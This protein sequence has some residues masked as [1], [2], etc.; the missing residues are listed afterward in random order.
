MPNLL[1]SVFSKDEVRYQGTVH[2]ENLEARKK[3]EEALET[4]YEEGK[5]V[6]VEGVDSVTTKAASG[7]ISYPLDTHDHIC[8]FIVGPS[9]ERFSIE[10]ETDGM[11]KEVTLIKKELRESIVLE[12]EPEAVVSLSFSFPRDGVHN[13]SI[14]FAKHFERA[15]TVK[16]VSEGLKNSAALLL[17]FF[18]KGQGST[19]DG[20]I[21]TLS[22]VVNHFTTLGN[23]CDRLSRI[24]ERLSIHFSPDA[25]LS[26][27]KE[28]VSDINDL[29]ILV[30]EEKALRTNMKLT[31]TDS[32]RIEI[33]EGPTLGSELFI[34]F[35]GT[36]EYNLFGEAIKL[37]SVCASINTV[38]KEIIPGEDTVRI[39]YG[40][41]DTKPMYISMKAFKTEEEAIQ[42]VSQ[43]MSHKMD[44]INAKTAWEYL[45]GK[46]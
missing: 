21:L 41:S 34:R 5:T 44:Y 35:T 10:V 39:L 15:K 18:K 14:T 45:K 19:N 26:V 8:K 6:A 22:D 38:V 46:D 33:N 25:L 1:K 43:I 42:E 23:L 20:T 2:F 29:Y 37:I 17:K 13:A 40:D 30:C 12:T 36:L 9:V 24:E 7:D 16:N 3:F 11:R 31:S 4:V 27:S 32:A 28:D